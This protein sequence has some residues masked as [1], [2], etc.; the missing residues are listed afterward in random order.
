MQGLKN[1]L[2]FPNIFLGAGSRHI[3]RC[4]PT[5]KPHQKLQTISLVWCTPLILA[6]GRLRR[7]D[8]ELEAS[9]GYHNGTLSQKA[10]KQQ[11]KTPQNKNTAITETSICSFREIK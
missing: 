11:Q 5:V 6:L 3:N 9:M 8:P 2:L 10:K 4:I 1:S 7:E